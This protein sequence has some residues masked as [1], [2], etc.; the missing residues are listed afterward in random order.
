MLVKIQEIR[1]TYI[2]L[3]EMQISEGTMEIRIKVS[4]GTIIGYSYTTTSYILKVIKGRMQYRHLH[5]FFIVALFTTTKPWNQPKCSSVNEWKNIQH[6]Y[7]VYILQP[8][9]RTKSCCLQKNRWK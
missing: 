4:Q 3:V 9:K 7:T 2:L 8:L 5:I 6:R 1:K